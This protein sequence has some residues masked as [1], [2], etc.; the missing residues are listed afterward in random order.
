MSNVVTAT[1]T[2]QGTLFPAQGANVPTDLLSDAAEVLSLN[3]IFFVS[4]RRKEK[5]GKEEERKEE[6]GGEYDQTMMNKRS[7]K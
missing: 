4:Q 7:N 3:S 2:L 6:R 1:G 5:E